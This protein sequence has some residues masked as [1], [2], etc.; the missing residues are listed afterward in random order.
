MFG[1]G[2][3]NITFSKDKYYT[4]Y[5]SFRVNNEL[6]N[7]QNTRVLGRLLNY[8]R[9]IYHT[10][11]FSSKTNKVRY[12]DVYFILRMVDVLLRMLNKT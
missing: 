9:K 1:S 4:E 5:C 3:L 6:V 2:Y 11:Y 8:S 7:P 10:N 12:Y